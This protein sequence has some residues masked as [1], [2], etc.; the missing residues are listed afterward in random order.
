VSRWVVHARAEFDARHA[1]T[2]YLGSPEAPHEHRW[3]VAVRVATAELNPEGYAVDFHALRA[4][5][6]R[7][8]AALD[9]TDLNLH[10][11]IGIPSPT[12]EHLAVVIAGW[13]EPEVRDFGAR[14]IGV[15]VWEGPDNRVDLELV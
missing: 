13:I 10:P 12:A 8:A 15:S 9:G 3:A 2:S 11:E 7:C 1:L 6:E 4:A 5:L 14:L